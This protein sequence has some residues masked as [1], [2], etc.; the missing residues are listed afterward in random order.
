MLLR[1]FLDF[2]L[3]VLWKKVGKLMKGIEVMDA[4]LNVSG[5]A[6]FFFERGEG[7]EGQF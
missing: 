7:K 1:L 5:V 6:K 2:D 4:G 3:K